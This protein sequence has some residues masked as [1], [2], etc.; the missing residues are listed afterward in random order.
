MKNWGVQ[1]VQNA[2]EACK[3]LPF[4]NAKIGKCGLFYNILYYFG[5]RGARKYFFGEN[6]PMSPHGT[7]TVYS[8]LLFCAWVRRTVYFLHWNVFYVRLNYHYKCFIDILLIR[9]R[10]FA[11][12]ISI[13]YLYFK[14]MTI[15][16]MKGSAGHFQNSN[17]LSISIILIMLILHVF[18]FAVELIPCRT[19]SH[20][21]C[22]HT[23]HR[24]CRLPA[25]VAEGCYW[26]K[27]QANLL[28]C[29]AASTYAK[30]TSTQ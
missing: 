7:A 14:L 29:P 21:K 9:L 3:N 8:T 17:R 28:A 25:Q 12:F 23:L 1:K 15:N 22:L 20:L 19:C 10:E 2:H 4:F 6:A 30:F 16:N 5:G 13:L 26:Y 18:C 27:Q 11:C 24:V